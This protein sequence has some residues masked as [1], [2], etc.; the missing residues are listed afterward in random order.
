MAINKKLIHFNTFENFNSKKLSANAEN[1]QYTLGINGAVTDGDPEILYQSICWIKDTKQQW[2]HGQIYNGNDID[3]SEYLTDEDVAAVATSGSYEDLQ[4]KPVYITLFDVLSLLNLAQNPD[5]VGGIESDNIAIKEALAANKIVLVPYER[6]DDASC[7][8]YATLVGYVEDLLY[9]KVITED[10][11]IIVETRF[12]AYDILGQE[13]TLR[14]WRDKQDTL[15][16]GAN[17]KTINGESLLGSGDM[18]IS[19]QTSI[20]YEAPSISVTSIGIPMNADT[21]VTTVLNT[22]MAFTIVLS[23]AA[24]KPTQLSTEQKWNLIFN[25]SPKLTEAPAITFISRFNILWANGVDPTFEVG[26]YYEVSFLNVGGTLLGVC[27][28]FSAA[29]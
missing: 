29:S 11:E 7:R 14:K 26:K 1:T 8:G 28:T 9:F 5:E 15:V 17:I 4:D 20:D 10:Y 21:V 12:N 13:V 27:G 18:T 3:V 6:S 16:S 25:I 24:Q 23:D 22:A 2:T 19:P